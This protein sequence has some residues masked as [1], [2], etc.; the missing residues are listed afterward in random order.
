LLLFVAFLWGV[1]FSIVKFA[2]AEISPIAFVGLRFLIASATMVALTRALGHSLKFQRQHL[3]HLIGLGLLGNTA[4]QLFFIYGISFTTAENSSL[5]LATVPAWVALVGTIV[6]VERVEPVGWV[7]I[8]LSL[9]GI[10]FIISGSDRL[11][12]FPFGGSSLR[13]DLLIL[14]GTLCWSLYTLLV[15][16]M[17]RRYSSVS[18]T[19]VT[20]TIGTVP[21][22]L[23][24]VPHATSIPWTGI[25]LVAWAAL[26]FSGVF[27]IGVAY[28]F[29]NYGVS[30]LG[31]AR[32]SIYSNLSLPA[33]LLTAWLWLHETLTPMQWWGTVLAMGGVILAR[34]FTHHQR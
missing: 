34:R 21:L 1:N 14:G 22:V 20:T 25:P 27:A 29:W 11:A 31:S 6:G 28:L 24:G 2:L 8:V 23:V 9:V 7:G 32:T 16:P 19:S 26:V 18:V 17:T 10:F 15:R 3:P 33:A 5:I 30:K 4:Y 13:G 12:D